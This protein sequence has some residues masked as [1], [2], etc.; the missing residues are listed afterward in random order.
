MIHAR[1]ILQEGRAALYIAARNGNL[2]ITKL[3]INNGCN[4]NT[5]NNVIYI[6]IICEMLLIFIIV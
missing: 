6:Y 1:Y 2:E 5:I 4:V 3:L